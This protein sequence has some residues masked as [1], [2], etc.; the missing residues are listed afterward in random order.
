MAARILEGHDRNSVSCI[1]Y[2]VEQI[3]L[4]K[5]V[6]NSV[7]DVEDLQVV[8]TGAERHALLL[9][10]MTA[11]VVLLE[12]LSLGLFHPVDEAI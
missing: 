6:V 12:P 9:H 2:R 1:W 3:G 10:C 7:L 5:R 11:K 8:Q 4:A